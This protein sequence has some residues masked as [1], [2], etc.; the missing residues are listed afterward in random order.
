MDFAIILASFLRV[1]MDLEVPLPA[2]GA[3]LRAIIR[4]DLLRAGGALPWE[5]LCAQL[6]AGGGSGAA[7]QARA[8]RFAQGAQRALARAAHEAWT[9]AQLEAYLVSGGLEGARAAAAGALWGKER[10]GVLAAVAGRAYAPAPRLLGA[11]TFSVATLTASFEG[12]AGSSHGA[13]AAGSAAPGVSAS[14]EPLAMLQL[15]TSAGP[16]VV[17]ASRGV[18]AAAAVAL[19]QARRAVGA[20]G[21]TQ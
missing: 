8:L 1:V 3:L 6:L 13:A 14:T 9:A 20:S 7:E 21:S 4:A 16:V 10:E 15:H 19:G 17:E 11:P 18:L 5:E 12:T 2:L